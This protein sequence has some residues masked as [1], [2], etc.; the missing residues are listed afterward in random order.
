MFRFRLICLAIA[1]F[2]SGLILGVMIEHYFV[3]KMLDEIE[4]NEGE[5]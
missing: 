1:L 2:E 4:E 5:E 3:S